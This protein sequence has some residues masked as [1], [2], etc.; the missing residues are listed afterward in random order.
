MPRSNG[1]WPTPL[2]Q[3]GQALGWGAME[4][5]KPVCGRGLHPWERERPPYLARPFS[6]PGK[7]YPKP[8]GPC[9]LGGWGP[10]PGS[11]FS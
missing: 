5:Y 9:S 8:K 7:P 6:L 2:P 10:P 11:C 1:A 4:G 3:P